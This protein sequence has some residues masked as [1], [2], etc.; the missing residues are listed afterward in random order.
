MP[1]LRCVISIWGDVKHAYDCDKESCEMT[2][3]LIESV[4][5]QELKKAL[6]ESSPPPDSVMLKAKTSKMSIQPED[7]LS[8]TILLSTEE[9]SIVAHIG[10]SLDPK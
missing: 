4:E 3:I 9:S 2:D 1:A 6:A 7:T 5:L 10:N 8:K